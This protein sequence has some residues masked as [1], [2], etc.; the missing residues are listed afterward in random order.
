VLEFL[1]RGHLEPH[2]RFVA[3]FLR[4]R[5]DAL[6]GVLEERLSGV[7]TWTRPDGGYFLWIELP[8]D[9]APLLEPARAAGV[10]FVPGAAFGGPPG[11]ARLSYS[12]PSVAEVRDGAHRLA[13]VVFAHV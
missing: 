6:L 5:R 7:A 2:L 1:A 10:D 12:F 8:V 11:S 13:D 9:A 3:G 4:E